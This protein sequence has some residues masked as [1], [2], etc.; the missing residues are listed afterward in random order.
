MGDVQAGAPASGRFSMN[1]VA[2]AVAP[3]DVKQYSDV[4]PEQTLGRAVSSAW[5]NVNPMPLVRDVYSA[6]KGDEEAATRIT[7]I[8]KSIGQGVSRQFRKSLNELKQGNVIPATG[9]ALGMLPLIGPPAVEAGE[10]IA[11]GDVAGGLGHAAGLLL[12]FGIPAAARAAKAVIPARATEALKSSAVTDY[13]RAFAPTGRINKAK[14]ATAV[15]G[16]P[17]RGQ[18]PPTPGLIERGEIALTRKGL[19]SKITTMTDQLGEQI[20]AAQAQ[21]PMGSRS[22]PLR[23]VMTQ[24]DENVRRALLMEDAAGNAIPL[25]PEAARA[26]TGEGRALKGLM[27]AASEP[28]PGGAVIDY[29]ILRRFRQAWDESIAKSGGYASPDFVTTA[30]KQVRKAFADGA[31]AELNAATPDIAAINR[32]YHFWRQAQDVIDAT[33]ERTRGQSQPLGQQLAQAAGGAAGAAKGGLG[34]AVAYALVFKNLR[35]L[36]TSTG[37]NTISAVTKDRIANY[38]AN[39]KIGDANRLILSSVV[40]AQAGKQES[41]PA[42]P[43]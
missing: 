5:E 11:R 21:I 22:L 36:T 33:V 8:P 42:P 12:P 9:Q 35:K 7:A 41:L 3:E 37:W 43:E 34:S 13:S 10:Q 19:Q 4:A 24:I 23:Q 18:L 30:Q 38:L 20:E 17:Q 25:T 2:D 16:I 6:L 27:Q 15:E 29:Q 39:G 1:D 26:V 31:R 40:A 14:T 32:E 28:A